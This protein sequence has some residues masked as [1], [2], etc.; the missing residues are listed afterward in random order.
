MPLLAICS[1]SNPT[2]S[3][4]REVIRSILSST[5][6]AIDGGGAILL[7]RGTHLLLRVALQALSLLLRLLLRLLLLLSRAVAGATPAP[8]KA[9]RAAA[10]S[11]RNVGDTPAPAND[12]S[13]AALPGRCARLA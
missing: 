1:N 4:T 12:V 10:L 9:I 5:E 13:T 3:S 11:G 8:D 7:K 2:S 6:T